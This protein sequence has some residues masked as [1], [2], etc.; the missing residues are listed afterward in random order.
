MKIKECTEEGTEIIIN[1]T[2]L[3]NT[4]TNL[5]RIAIEAFRLMIEKNTSA[6][7]N[8]SEGDGKI[9]Q[10][11]KVIS[12]IEQLLVHSAREYQNFNNG[13]I[14]ISSMTQQKPH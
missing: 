14:T 9:T 2:A 4:Q 10:F 12:E 3:T 11:N 8:N 6:P 5:F 1:G 7:N 13:A